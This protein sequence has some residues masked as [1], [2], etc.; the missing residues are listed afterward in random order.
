MAQVKIFGIKERLL[1]IRDN[2]F[3]GKHGDEIALNHKI[4]V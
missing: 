4:N 1:T 3:R 2:R